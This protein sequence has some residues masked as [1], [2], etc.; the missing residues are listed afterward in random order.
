LLEHAGIDHDR[1]NAISR[2]AVVTILIPVV[3]MNPY[4]NA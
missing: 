3:G 2:I 1:R 4:Y